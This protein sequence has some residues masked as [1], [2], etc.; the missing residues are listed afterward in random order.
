M[1]ASVFFTFC[2]LGRLLDGIHAPPQQASEKRQGTK[3]R[4]LVY[5]ARRALLS[6]RKAKIRHV[7]RVSSPDTGIKRPTIVG[8]VV[9]PIGKPSAGNRHAR[10]VRSSR[11]VASCALSSLGLPRPHIAKLNPVEP[12]R[13]RDPYERWCERGGAARR[14][15][16]PIVDPTATICGSILLWRTTRH[17]FNN[18]VGCGTRTGETYRLQ[19]HRVGGRFRRSAAA[20]RHRSRRL[21]I[22]HPAVL[23]AI[24]FEVSLENA[25]S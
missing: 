1:E 4:R 9:K 16:I 24:W 8:L 22:C 21:G 20:R 12:P 18:M 6:Y 3:S 25:L 19:F 15:P 14:P 2:F 5:G 23:I 13:L 17:S 7:P 10:F 11:L